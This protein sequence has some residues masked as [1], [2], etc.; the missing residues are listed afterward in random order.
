MVIP[1]LHKPNEIK[2]DSLMNSR[3]NPSKPT[4]WA[5]TLIIGDIEEVSQHDFDNHHNCPN[6]NKNNTA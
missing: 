4:S 1:G 2:L 5:T 6:K 3:Y